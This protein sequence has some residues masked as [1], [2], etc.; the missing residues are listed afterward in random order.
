MSFSS[1]KNISP[2]AFYFAS[3]VSFVAASVIKDKSLPFYYVLLILGLG[4][5][6]AGMAKRTRTKR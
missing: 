4:L 2:I 6:F 3:V 1:F 5:F